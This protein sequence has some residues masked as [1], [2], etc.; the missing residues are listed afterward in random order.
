MS[1]N[2]QT[3]PQEVSFAVNSKDITEFLELNGVTTQTVD[4]ISYMSP[5]EMTTLGSNFTVLVSC[6]E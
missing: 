2:G 6:W 3:L 5:E 4:Q 1:V